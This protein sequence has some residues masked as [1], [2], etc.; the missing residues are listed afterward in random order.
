MYQCMTEAVFLI[1]GLSRSSHFKKLGGRSRRLKNL[2]SAGGLG[3]QFFTYTYAKFWA[4]I[5]TVQLR[6]IR[7]FLN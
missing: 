4:H 1:L 3:N 2:A 5:E 7:Q 6:I